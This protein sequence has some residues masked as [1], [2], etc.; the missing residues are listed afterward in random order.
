MDYGATNLCFPAMWEGKSLYP[1]I[2]TGY[3]LTP[4]VDDKIVEKLD[5]LFY[6]GSAFLKV[7]YHPLHI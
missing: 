7:V 2:E 4:D 1:K 3:A 5:I 6:K